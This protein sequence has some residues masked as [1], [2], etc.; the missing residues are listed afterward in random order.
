VLE[1]QVLESVPGDIPHRTFIDEEF[2]S[3]TVKPLANGD[4]QVYLIEEGAEDG[5][6]AAHYVAQ[7][8]NIAATNFETIYE[9]LTTKPENG[10]GDGEV[11]VFINSADASTVTAL[12]GFIDEADPD[13]A[14]G[15]NS[16]RLV[17]SLSASVPGRVLGKI[18]QCWVVQWNAVPANYAL[19]VITSGPRALGLREPSEAELRGFQAVA[20][21][22]DHPY[23]E[24][25][26][27]RRLGFGAYNRVGAYVL[28]FSGGD[29][30]YDI[31]SGFNAAQFI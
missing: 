20:D 11:I 12:S 7:T 3:L 28:Q 4:S 31:P 2:G 23:F 22:N 29:T 6:T 9:E 15:A 10:S 5:A 1:K 8:T 30:T 13:I 25:Q 18:A 17:G 24:R 26:F 21:R 27:E 19:G 16:D 14:L